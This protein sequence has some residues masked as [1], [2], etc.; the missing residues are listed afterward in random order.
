MAQTAG[1]SEEDLLLRL[2]RGEAE[3]LAELFS[4]HRERLA[5]GVRF[6]LHPALR[7]RVDVEDILQEVYLRAAQR[8]ASFAGC[9]SE[10][11]FVWVRMIAA[12]ALVDLHR[13]HL[14]AQARDA[15]REVY[16]LGGYSAEATSTSL[17]FELAAD[18]TSPSQ[19]A[20]RKEMAEQVERAIE[21][22]DP[23]DREILA[24]RHFEEL[25]NGEVAQ[26]LGIQEKAASIRYV[27][28]LAR[29]KKIL[30]RLSDFDL[31]ARGPG[32]SGGGREA[33]ER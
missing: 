23:I 5:R 25:S 14:G 27:R 10:S 22:M 9:S 32:A 1:D 30:E 19:A 21:S 6:R 13:R 8:M 18:R 4:R 2:Q 3:A 29:L 17:A 11:F 28:A 24:L 15:G 20:I 16:G 26:V 7:R 31:G 12:Q 33:D